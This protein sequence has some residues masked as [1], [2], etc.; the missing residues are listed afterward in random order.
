MCIYMCVCGSASSQEFL[1]PAGLAVAVWAEVQAK[2]CVSCGFES[3]PGQV[4][5]ARHSKP[6]GTA[7]LPRPWTTLIKRINL[8][9]S[10][11]LSLGPSLQ[12]HI[13]QLSF[14]QTHRNSFYILVKLKKFPKI[15]DKS[16]TVGG[17]KWCNRKLELV[18]AAV[19]KE[20]ALRVWLFH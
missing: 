13:V 5:G 12:M 4:E 7:P 8:F 19:K 17:I 20:I 9:S 11:G 10:K 18:H 14:S 6:L 3:H 1:L 15:P 16:N 2:S